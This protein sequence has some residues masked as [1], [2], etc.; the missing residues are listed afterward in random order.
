MNTPL[1]DAEVF[2]TRTAHVLSWKSGPPGFPSRLDH[3]RHLVAV[4]NQ[5]RV[6]E[7]NLRQLRLKL[8]CAGAQAERQGLPVLGRQLKEWGGLDA[9]W[10]DEQENNNS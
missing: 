2:L 5:A 10:R 3:R 1:D 4:L 8:I 7:D 6:L 9:P